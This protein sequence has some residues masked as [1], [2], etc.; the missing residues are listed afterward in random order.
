VETGTRTLQ[1]KLF[2]GL[3]FFNGIDENYC[4]Q[5]WS[6]VTGIS[7]GRFPGFTDGED[8]S[9]TSEYCMQLK[10]INTETGTEEI[11]ND[12]HLYCSDAD[13]IN[14]KYSI[15]RIEK[16]RVLKSVLKSYK[17]KYMHFDQWESFFKWHMRQKGNFLIF[18][19]KPMKVVNPYIQPAKVEQ[20]E[21][22]DAS[23]EMLTIESLLNLPKK[24]VKWTYYDVLGISSNSTPDQIYKAYKF[25]AK[26][27]HPDKFLKRQKQDQRITEQ[28]M[29]QCMKLIGEAYEILKEPE[30][31]R[32]YDQDLANDKHDHSKWNLEN[33]SYEFHNPYNVFKKNK[34][35]GLDAR[36]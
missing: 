31:R 8:R 7:F 32:Q 11:I 24:P 16:R 28:I 26:K 17:Q 33:L 3:H 36:F 21:E 23:S 12:E 1:V 5:T 2:K 22:E 34:L 25:K 13:F 6:N 29:T 30:K 35:F 9:E 19:N 15:L 10:H 14:K 20:E 18:E 4:L 27:W